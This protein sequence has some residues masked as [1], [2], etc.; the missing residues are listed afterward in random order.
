[1]GSRVVRC[2][3]GLASAAFWTG[4][5]DSSGTKEFGRDRGK[6]ARHPAMGGFA[7]VSGRADMLAEGQTLDAD[8]CWSED[9]GGGQVGEKPVYAGGASL[10]YSAESPGE[11]TMRPLM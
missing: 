10:C 5:S 9:P 1:M 6:G 3:T 4:N 2:L 11:R 7:P 8:D